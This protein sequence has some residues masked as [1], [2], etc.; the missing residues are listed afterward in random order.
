[1]RNKFNLDE[2]LIGNG[3]NRREILENKYFIINEIYYN[4][5]NDDYTEISPVEIDKN[6]KFSL[7]ILLQPYELK[8]RK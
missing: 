6:E 8:V 1:M 7:F 3:I 4:C 2:C 5:I